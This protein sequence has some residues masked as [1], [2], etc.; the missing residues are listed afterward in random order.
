MVFSIIAITKMRFLGRCIG[1]FAF[2][3]DKR[4]RNLAIANIIKALNVPAG[5]ARVIAKKSFQNQGVNILD[6]LFG[7]AG[8]IQVIGYKYINKEK[9]NIFILGHFGNWELMG[10]IAVKK[11]IRI[12]A[13]G[14]E[15]KNRF[16]DW[17]IR[18][19]RA[20]AGIEILNKKGSFKYLLSALKDGKSAAILIDQYAGRRGIF[21]DFC[22]I[23]T[24]TTHSPVLLSLKTGCPVV[25]VFIIGCKI[26]VE[27]P[28]EITKD[29]KAGT[30]AMIRP[31]ERYVRQHPEQWWWV[32]R[33]WR[34][35]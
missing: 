24:S 20:K 23:P 6:F 19:Q 27:E 11:G 22:G 18:K 8:H 32:H 9:G 28:I 34:N 29:I 26:I 35:Q 16:A 3:L 13:V 7:W 1:L 12:V 4:H 2:H 17:F 15:I 10:R 21:V 14:R 5:K 25:P 33:R 30:Q 31:L